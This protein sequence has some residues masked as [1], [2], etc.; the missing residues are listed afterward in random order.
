MT[1]SDKEKADVLADFFTSVF[2]KDPGN[3]MP[4]IEPKQ[5]P[6]LNDIIITPE[7]VKKKLD[8]L[9]VNKSPGPDLLHPRLLKELS[10]VLS[11]PLSII[12]KNSVDLGVLPDEWKCANIT[13]LFKKGD[14]K[15]AGNY[16][17]VSL[18][19]VICKVLE[20]IIRGCFV[21][22][23]KSNKLFS[24]KQFGFI[25]GRST[26]L[27]LIQV[28]DQWTEILDEGGCVN[29]A[30]CDFMKAFD[31]VCHKR[32][33]HKLKLYN[34]GPVFTKWIASFLDGRTQKVIIN[35]VSSDP[36]E[37]TSGIPQGSV[38]G[39]ILFVL[40]INDLPE[41]IKHGSVPF[42]FADDTKVYHKINCTKDCEDLQEDIKAMQLWSEKWLL[43][44]HPDK[45]KCMRIGK[46]DIDLFAYK[47]KDDGKA[48]EFSKFEKDIGVVIDNKLTFENHIN[49]KVN[50][51][52]S[53]MG[54][55]R[56]TFEFLDT[57]TFRLLYTAMVRPH[58]EYAN[59]VWCPYLKKHIDMLENVQR[60]A[61]KSIPG[62][63]NLSYE[64]RLRKINIPT[65]AYRRSRGDMIE[66]YKI[67]TGKYDPEVSKFIKLREDSYTRGH[68][69]KI[70][71][72]RPRLNV[73]KYS[74][75]LRVV[76]LWNSL[77]SSVVE[78]KTVESFERRLD[79]LWREQPAYYNYNEAIKP[80]GYDKNIQ[81]EEELELVQQVV[82]DL[83][84]EEDL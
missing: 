10:D 28:L 79:K 75:C 83:L 48:M 16:R 35:G 50:K 56:R 9:K 63:S 5:V 81:S 21:E 65:L 8:N 72:S 80:T 38:L 59:Q 60:R 44:F 1:E 51:A 54:V 32:L 43:C 77:P 11:Y 46:S 34:I 61:T 19:S 84:P 30:Y 25:S 49:E 17:P 52:N 62:L 15:Y 71:K 22:H 13:A 70:Y 20:S 55:I 53:V 29:V 64:E 4:D 45:C 2:T 31:K 58:I 12:F 42:L 14:K 78:A 7:L 26:V 76:D 18:T 3:E 82:T 67:L 57:K 27:Q 66:T 41:V 33:V 6:E 47:L 39:P 40:F 68:M 73:R 23:M 36:K 24:D 74:F 69:Y 37:V